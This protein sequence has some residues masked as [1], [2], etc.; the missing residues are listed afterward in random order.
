MPD[1]KSA[2]PAVDKAAAILQHLSAQDGACTLTEICKGTGLPKSSAFTLLNT[3]EALDYVRRGDN[4]YTLGI[5]LYT[6][7][8]RA[9]D[10]VISAKVYRPALQKLRDVSGF[11]VHFC[12]Y[13][14]AKLTVLDKLDGPGVVQFKAYKGQR[15][16]V[17]TS[18]GGKA[19]AAFLPE[20][21]LVNVLHAG[22]DHFTAMSIADPESFVTHLDGIR[23]TGYSIDE[24]EGEIG[25]RCLGAPVFS[26]GG[27]VFGGISL[28]TIVSQ[29]PLRDIP[30]Y[31]HLLLE[32]AA[33]ISRALSYTGPYPLLG[34]DPQ[35]P[36]P[37]L[38]QIEAMYGEEKKAET[39]CR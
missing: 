5:R 31:V 18:A 39:G 34:C 17:N 37:Y 27:Q 29:L 9:L 19:L 25:V 14:N 32:T 20:D 21:E 6:L 10:H 22:F 4:G 38:L 12:L 3:L 15:K 24:G 1:H 13:D 7:G 36:H 2:A 26:R 8:I 28:T 11:T 35:R 30:R 33:E 23:Q 16:R